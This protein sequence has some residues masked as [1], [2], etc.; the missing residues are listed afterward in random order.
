MDID[1]LVNPLNARAQSTE[2]SG[3]NGKLPE[4]TIVDCTHTHT[5]VL[6]L[7]GLCPG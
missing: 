6:Q 1:F 3:I 7:Y 5:T 4:P 2:F